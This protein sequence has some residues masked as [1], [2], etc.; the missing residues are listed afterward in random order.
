[1]I[2]R[3][4]KILSVAFL[5]IFF[6][7]N[8][9]QQYVT[10]FFS[11][12]EMVSVGFYS[13]I[14]I[15]LSFTLS[16]QISAVFVSKYGAKKC[17]PTGAIFYSLFIISLLSGS[18]ILIY[19]ASAL[20]GIAAALLWT[21]QGSYLIRVS[22]EKSYG[23]N[24]GFFSS[25]Q[26][27]GSALGVLFLGVLVAA[28]YFKLSF[29]LFS[30]FPVLG[31]LLM[32][33]LKNVK[34]EKQPNNFALIKKSLTSKTALRISILYFS[35]YF[36]FG[37]VIGIVPLEIKKLI[38]VSYIGFFSS[39]FYIMPIIFS[40]IFGKISD[41]K[42]RKFMVILAYVICIIGLILLY[43]SGGKI[44][45]I[46]GIILL[47]INFSIIWPST[48]ALIGDVSTKANLE[49]LTALFGMAS[50]IAVVSSLVISSLFLT[51][52]I[53]L[54]SLFVMGISFI[55]LLP[56]LKLKIEKLKEL[57]SQEIS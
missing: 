46:S 7:F 1:M 39:L 12:A 32:F 47:A 48:M 22:D 8:G 36:I 23:A 25:L 53:Y 35:F 38:G 45:L 21:G 5:L 49:F 28:L 10:P 55:V 43:L 42:E 30:I 57:I 19:F 50:N 27:L 20:L 4:T 26:S 15:Y 11:E 37:L 29:L 56:I 16:G 2:S 51:K 34:V 24:A 6:G 13:L 31:F 52:T 17:M 9:V 54:I 33:K 44:L 18:A 40:F 14:I 3:Q 41:V